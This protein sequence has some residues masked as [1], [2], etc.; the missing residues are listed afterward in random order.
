MINQVKKGALSAG[1]VIFTNS[2]ALM[3]FN[4]LF[5]LINQ[6]DR[7][8]STWPKMIQILQYIDPDKKQKAVNDKKNYVFQNGTIAFQDLTVINEFNQFLFK[9]STLEIPGKSFTFVT[10]VSGIQKSTLFK[11]LLR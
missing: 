4:P 5:A 6:S 9:N 7:Y 8:T 3:L 10:G 2:L 11:L 1:D